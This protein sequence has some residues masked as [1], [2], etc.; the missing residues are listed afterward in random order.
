MRHNN[1]IATFMI[2]PDAKEWMDIY[3][4]VKER[5]FPVFEQVPMFIEGQVSL[6]TASE[7]S[8]TFEEP[9]PGYICCYYE[10]LHQEKVLVNTIIVLHDSLAKAVSPE[11]WLKYQMETFSIAMKALMKF[12]DRMEEDAY[13]YIDSSKNKFRTFRRMAANESD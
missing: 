1:H 4:D 11:N 13:R 8:L 10:G 12:N 7:G 3:T 2:M 6:L 5:L 9:N